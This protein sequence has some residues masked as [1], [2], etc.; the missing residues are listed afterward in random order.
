[1][2][3]IVGIQEQVSLYDSLQ[4]QVLY[5][6]AN[7]TMVAYFCHII[8]LTCQIFTSSCQI[9]T[10]SCQIFMLI[11]QIFILSCQIFY[12]VLSVLYVDLSDLYVDMSLIH[13]LENK[14]QQTC[15]CPINALQIHKIM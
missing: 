15:S 4:E 5:V 14:S 10:S 13:L 1:M 2:I 9:F 3:V 7:I 11:C 6:L 8:W 12:V